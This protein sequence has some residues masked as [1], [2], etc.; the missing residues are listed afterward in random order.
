M[1]LAPL[2]TDVMTFAAK[3]L[4][5]VL[6]IGAIVQLVVSLARR[7]KVAHPYGSLEV[8]RLND[9]FDALKRGLQSGMAQGPSRKL[10]LKALKKELKQEEKAPPSEGKRTVYVVD[11]DGDLMATQTMGLREEITAIVSVAKPE[12]EVVVRLDSGGGGVPHYGLAAAQL[13]RL[14]ASK[15]KVTVCID[16]VAASGGYMM[17]CVADTVV[18]APFSAIGSI[19]VVAQ[20]PNVRRFLQRQSIDVE[21][22]T[23]GEFK[24]TVS[25]FGEVTEKGK[26]KL[27]EQLEETHQLF[28][29]FVKEHRP[30]LDIDKV[31]TGE[32]WLGTKAKALGLVDQ[33]MTSD[34]YLLGKAKE[35]DVFLVTFYPSRSWRERVMRGGLEFAERA[36][37]RAWSRAR[38][39]ALT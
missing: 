38:Q 3:A 24:R 27:Q 17:A 4:I 19:G 31:A 2:T 36:L 22:M 34:E 20:V 6:A 18:A 30:S 5:L 7:S 28:K 37:L 14:K 16:Y 32:Y 33:V 9:R 1:D 29:A 11:F 35:A 39:L 26:A 23:A 10:A 21:E 13:D 15:L 12:D 8:K 25:L